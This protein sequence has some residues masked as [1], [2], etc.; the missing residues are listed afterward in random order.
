MTPLR[1]TA[2]YLYFNLPDIIEARSDPRIKTFI[3][4]LGVRVVVCISPQLDI[5]CTNAVKQY[6]A[7]NNNS[8]FMFH[9]FFLKQFAYKQLFYA[10]K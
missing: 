6:H 3:M 9:G 4:L 7:N 8:P 1:V 5:L 2:T 10:Q